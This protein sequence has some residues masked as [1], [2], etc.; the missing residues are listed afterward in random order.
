MYSDLDEIVA[1]VLP[2]GSVPRPGVIEYLR[3]WLVHADADRAVGPHLV[4][5]LHDAELSA[6]AKVLRKL[7]GNLI[8]TILAG[9]LA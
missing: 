7:G 6:E 1:E 8:V 3:L 9:V 4:E 5:R 2:G